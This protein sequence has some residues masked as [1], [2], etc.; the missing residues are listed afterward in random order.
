MANKEKSV[1]FAT[2][3]SGISEPKTRILFSHGDKGGVGK[4]QTSRLILDFLISNGQ[5]CALV[6]ADT[7]NPDVKRMFINRIP[8]QA[9]DL[10]SRDGWDELMDYFDSHIGYN[11]IVNLPAGIGDYLEKNLDFINIFIKSLK[12]VETEMWWTMSITHDA[13]NLLDKALN[14]YGSFFNKVRVVCNMFWTQDNE[15][16]YEAWKESTLRPKVENKYG[17]TIY[18]RSL[19]HRVFAKLITPDKIMPFSEAMDASLGE[20]LGFTRS[21]GTRL[22]EYLEINA[23][24]LSRVFELPAANVTKS[25]EAVA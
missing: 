23:R 22:Q 9:I 16:G 21:E 6:E 10:R 3:E 19:N 20:S 25:A 17:Q 5:K 13:I 4:S 7:A 8:V 24:W 2:N 1:A 12:N 14:Q 15:A 18:M 11:I